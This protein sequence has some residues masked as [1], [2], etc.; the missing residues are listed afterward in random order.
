M[1]DTVLLTAIN[2]VLDSDMKASK[3]V[4]SIRALIVRWTIAG[5]SNA[6]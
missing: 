6:L 2:R 1:I 3:K 4:K 5:I